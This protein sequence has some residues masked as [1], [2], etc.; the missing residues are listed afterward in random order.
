[1]CHN[2]A[3]TSKILAI[4][5]TG[6]YMQNAKQTTSKN[7]ANSIENLTASLERYITHFYTTPI[8]NSSPILENGIVQVDNDC[9]Y[10]QYIANFCLLNHKQLLASGWQNDWHKVCND[11]HSVDYLQN[12][13]Q[14]DCEIVL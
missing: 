7:C 10:H 13:L 4:I 1:M 8:D 11:R 12:A 5:A 3:T 9:D 2:F 14:T 6:Y